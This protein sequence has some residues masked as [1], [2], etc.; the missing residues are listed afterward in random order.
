ML[1]AKEMKQIQKI[2]QDEINQQEIAGCN[3]L[4]LHQGKEVFYHEDG[5]ANV[6]QQTPIKRDSIFRL[7]SLSKPITATAVMILFERGALDLYEPVSQFLPGFQNQMVEVNGR[8][9]PVQR[10]MMIKDLLS[11]SSGLVYEGTHLAGQKTQALFQSIE[12]ALVNPSLSSPS[13]VDAMNQLG[14]Y[15]LAFHPGTSWEYGT[16]ADVLGAI[17]EV[18]SK[19][20]FGSFLQEELFTPLGM[21]DTGF[22]VPIEKQNR[23]TTVYQKQENSPLSIYSR[24]YLG[25]QNQM[26]QNPAFESGGAGLVSTVDDYAKFANML[27]QGGKYQDQQILK[28]STVAFLTG[29]TLHTKL[30][31][32]FEDWVAL[33]GH[34]YGNLMRVLTT[35]SQAGVLGCQGE[36]GWDGWLGAYF[37]NCP[38]EELTILLMMQKTDAGTTTLTRKI[39]NILIS[40]LTDF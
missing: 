31:V 17:V 39:R 36:Y 5:Y 23:L 22:F 29:S 35:P 18:V 40:S 4:V 14:T 28:P 38:K 15:P 13:T 26:V 24:N 37:C 12:D 33:A 11:M 20:S 32:I 25:I 21:K 8:L 19:K 34:S 16:S 9:E 1:P 30:Q 2:I 3:L 6:E 10:D 7:Y 27:M